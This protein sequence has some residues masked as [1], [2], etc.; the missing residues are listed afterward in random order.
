MLTGGTSVHTVI[1]NGGTEFVGDGGTANGTVINDGG[2]Q[3]VDA[4]GTAT[5]TV[6]TGGYQYVGGTASGTGW[7]RTRGGRRRIDRCDDPERRRS[8]RLH[9][10]GSASGTIVEA[11]GFQDVYNGAVTDTDLSGNQQVQAGGVAVN[12]VIAS[13]AT[14]YIGSGGATAGTVI[15]AGGLQ[16]LDAGSNSTGTVV[17]GG[18]EYVGGTALATTVNS[19]GAQHVGGGGVAEGTIVS[20]GSQQVYQDGTASYAVVLAGGSQYVDAGAT[21][22]DTTIHGG[23]QYVAGTANGSTVDGGGK[24]V[25]GAGGTANDTQ[26]AN[27]IEYVSAGGTADDVDFAG[28]SASLLLDETSGLTG[29]VSNFGIGDTIDLLNTSVSSFD[30]D[31]TTLTLVTSGG[32]RRLPVRRRGSRHRVQRG[33]RRPRRNG[34]IAVAA[35]AVLGEPGAGIRRRR[36]HRCP[37]CGTG[38]GHADQ[39]PRLIDPCEC[40]PGLAPVRI[41]VFGCSSETGDAPAPS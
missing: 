40:A 32:R 22:T 15:N 9:Y 34:D 27:G 8:A 29:T 25:V 5:D 33:Q 12:T 37:G 23:Y 26:L 1:E 18:F 39:R 10:G 30:F 6:I 28:A 24:L 16:Y 11:G 17:N 4:G 13:G 2:F 21:A 38:R 35:L 20:N 41:F 36:R 7:W 31:G 19:G 3:Y 14:A